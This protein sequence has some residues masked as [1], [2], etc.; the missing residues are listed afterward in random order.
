ML[1]RSIAVGTVD[2]LAKIS[3]NE[4]TRTFN[5]A[6][7]DPVALQAL[8]V[9][10]T[11]MPTDRVVVD[12]RLRALYVTSNPLKLSEVAALLQKLDRPGRQV[13]LQARIL[14]F[15]DGAKLDVETALN[16]VYNHWW[17][18]Y[19]GASGGK[20]GFIDDNRLGRNFTDP[21][22]KSFSP[23]RTDLLTPMHG[24]WREFDVAFRA[25]EE[26]GLGKTLARNR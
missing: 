10:L 12:P 21:A 8:L 19:G 24:I 14:E 16:A 15:S 25:V 22:D 2:G 5:V 26:K 6:Y 3:G 7:A 20:G 1:F 4:E 13:M 17:F 9:N 18:T 11:K 23:G